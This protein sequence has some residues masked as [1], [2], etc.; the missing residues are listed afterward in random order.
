[1]GELAYVTCSS[2]PCNGCLREERATAFP[3]PV[4]VP[5]EGSWGTRMPQT[6]G[7]RKS[8]EDSLA[9]QSVP[10]GAGAGASS[11]LPSPWPVKVFLE[12]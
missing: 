11:A 12:M 7:Q 5:G 9:A 10:A 6:R 2:H 8:S 4:L 1:M 3:H